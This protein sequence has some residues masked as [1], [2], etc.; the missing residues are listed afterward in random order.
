MARMSRP[1]INRIITG[2][3]P[4]AIMFIESHSGMNELRSAL[5]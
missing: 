4:A 5:R 1:I 2:N 3:I